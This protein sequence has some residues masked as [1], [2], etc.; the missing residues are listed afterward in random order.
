MENLHIDE[1]LPGFALGSL[2]P[3]EHREVLR[4][5]AGCERCQKELLTYQEV[6]EH[7]PYAVQEFDPAPGLRTA[8]LDMASPGA[9]DQPAS[10][11]ASWW[12]GLATF[13]RRNSLAW[14]LSSLAL[15]L[16]FGTST[17]WLWGQLQAPVLQTSMQ[18]LVLEA[19][20]MNP[21][22]EAILV[23]DREGKEGNLTV[24][25]LPELPD[26][27]QYQLWLID[28]ERRTD[29]GVFS[30]GEDGYGK[31]HIDV[32]EGLD[33]YTGLGVTIEPAGGSPGPTGEKVLGLDL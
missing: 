30:V 22:A 12:S 13:F 3:E 26:N 5:L 23:L 19:A 32:P 18:V 20:D 16:I 31:L 6:V 15:I 4:H 25:G 27:L 11:A 21:L 29:A 14:G 24:D 1:L 33:T 8:I 7:L 9:G 10:A 28:G 17:L 2:D